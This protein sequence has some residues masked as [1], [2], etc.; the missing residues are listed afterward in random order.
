M[1]RFSIRDVLWLTLVV[2]LAL[3]WWL[4]HQ[5]TA[6]R[7]T[8]AKDNISRS[9]DVFRGSPHAVDAYFERRLEFGLPY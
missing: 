3:G 1:F 5:R 4:Q 2:G 9:H 7:E 8:T 6:R